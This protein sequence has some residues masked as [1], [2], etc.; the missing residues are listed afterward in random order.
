MNSFGDTLFAVEDAG[1]GGTPAKRENVPAGESKRFR[2]Y[3][4]RQE[5]LLPPSLD[6][7]LPTG[8][9]AR[10]ISDVVD[11]ML[12]LSQVYESYQVKRGYPPYDPTMMLKV[13]VYGYSIGVTSSRELARRCVNDVA[14][15]WLTGNQLPEYR[16]L[17]RFR[18]RHLDALNDLFLQVLRLCAES[19][20]VKLGRVALDGTKVQAAASKHKAMSYSRIVPK[21]S[22][23]E[24][25]VRDLLDEAERVDAAEDAKYGE[26]SRGDEIPEELRTREAR[27]RKLKEAKAAIEKEAAEKA[28][29]QAVKKATT[30]ELPEED[31][32]AAGEKAAEGVVPDPKAQRNFTDPESRIMKTKRGFEYAYNA[33]AIATDGEQIILA[34][35]VTQQATDVHQLVPL[36]HALYETLN[37]AGI[38]EP[39]GVLLADAGYCSE[40]NLEQMGNLG[41]NVLVATGR[42]RAG[43]TFP[44]G[45][46]SG[47]T[48]S[49]SPEGA[50]RRE[51]M[52][53]AL[54]TPEGA[55]A[56]A[57][58]KAIIEPVFGQMK[59]RQQAGKFRLRGVQQVTAEFTLHALCHNLRKLRNATFMLPQNRVGVL[60]AAG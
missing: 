43:E 30:N 42:Q 35:T 59:T 6:D 2:T 31:I 57:R 29:A 47:D 19:G 51:Q 1:A 34:T 58:R 56:Y 37:E 27:L 5:F 13:V 25:Q 39:V 54:K 50:T 3:N 4:Q 21:I 53:Y 46:A 41:V 17:A 36:T 22:E 16:A 8:S 10:F 15:R 49:I 26:G 40:A 11:S 48:G 44:G 33:Q 24:Q 20:L 12:D 28:T 60:R 32:Q 45:D 52:A 14:F 7:W 38:T 23:L 55:A 18:K 9:E